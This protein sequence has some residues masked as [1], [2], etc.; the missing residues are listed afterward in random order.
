LSKPHLSRDPL[1][2]GVTVVTEKLPKQDTQETTETEIFQWTKQWY[3]VAVV[4]HIDPTRPQPLQ[5]LGKNLVLWRDG[6]GKMVLL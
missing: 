5:L 4:D 6:S 2:S 3:P 1:K